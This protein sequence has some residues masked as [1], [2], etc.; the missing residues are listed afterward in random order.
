MISF[1]DYQLNSHDYIQLTV[2]DIRERGATSLSEALKSN[3]TLTK[4]DM[5][6]NGERKQK[7]TKTSFTHFHSQQTGLETQG[8][9][10]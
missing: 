6:C 9:H 1:Q 8:Q 4:L 3:T 7:H 10:Y 2:S 5:N